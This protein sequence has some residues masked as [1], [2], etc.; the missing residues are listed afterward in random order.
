M[1]IDMNDTES[2]RLNIKVL[3]NRLR[4]LEADKRSVHSREFI[5][6]NKIK[7]EDVQRSD[8]PGM[9]WWGHIAGFAKWLALNSNKKWACWNGTIYCSHDLIHGRF[10]STPAYYQDLR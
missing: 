6:V 7:R 3:E 5:R 10:E 4:A 8:D 1:N 2:I 9:P